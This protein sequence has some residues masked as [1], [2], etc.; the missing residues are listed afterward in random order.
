MYLN[1]V[2]GSLGPLYATNGP[3]CFPWKRHFLRR[4][5]LNGQVASRDC[6][7]INIVVNREKLATK[8]ALPL[9]CLS[10]WSGRLDS[11]QRPHGPEPCALP[12]A[13]RP[14]NNFQMV[15]KAGIEPA[16]SR[17]PSERSTSEP[18]PEKEQSKST[19]HIFYHYFSNS[20]SVSFISV[21]SLI[22]VRGFFSSEELGN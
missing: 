13:L 2:Q 10:K 17:T 12:S 14:V 20:S 18:L 5:F 4:A 11:N 3:I 19:T 15:G 8:K 1:Q 21:K 6:D 16:I 9:K 7:S 22:S